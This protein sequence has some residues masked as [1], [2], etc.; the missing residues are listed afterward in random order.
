MGNDLT[1]A[2]VQIEGLCKIWE[3][4]FLIHFKIVKGMFSATEAH[5]LQAQKA[6]RSSLFFFLLVLFMLFDELQSSK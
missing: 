6:Y 2:L 4:T 5:F 3:R 1:V